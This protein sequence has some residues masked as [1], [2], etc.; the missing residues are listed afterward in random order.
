MDVQPGRR[1]P[2]P[3]ED[4]TGRGQKAEKEEGGR[5]SLDRSCIVREAAAIVGSYDTPATLRR[6]FCCFVFT[7]RLPNALTGRCSR[8]GGRDEARTESQAR[9][10]LGPG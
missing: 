7:R 1:L 4:E 9:R 3:A 8:S 2:L 6:L 10:G 5:V